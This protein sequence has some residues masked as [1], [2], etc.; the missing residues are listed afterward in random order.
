MLIGVLLSAIWLDVVAPWIWLYCN[1]QE[2]P[3]WEKTFKTKKNKRGQ[4]TKKVKEEKMVLGCFVN[5][6][7]CQ[8]AILS[9]RHFV[10]AGQKH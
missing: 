8:P 4:K 6:P 7:F 2:R 9:T 3:L 1:L 10:N 5:L